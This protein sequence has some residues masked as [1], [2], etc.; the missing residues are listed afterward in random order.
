MTNLESKRRQYD[1]VEVARQRGFVD[2][3]MIDDDLGRSAAARLRGPDSIVS[4]RGCALARSAPFCALMHRGSLEMAEIG[5]T[6]S[7]YVGLSKPASSISTASIIPV[8]R[9]IACSWE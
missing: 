8:G 2:V 1:L 5:I 7:N 4:S 3:E 6:C 9:M